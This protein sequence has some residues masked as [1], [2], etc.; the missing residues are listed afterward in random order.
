[1]IH[2]NVNKQNNHFLRE[3]KLNTGLVNPAIFSKE[4]VY[5]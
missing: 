4:S 2:Q 5:S 1:M 3:E